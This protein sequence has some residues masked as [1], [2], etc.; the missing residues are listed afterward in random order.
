[1]AL[2]DKR[3]KSLDRECVNA[4]LH[5]M[6][7]A[8]GHVRCGKSKCVS[9]YV[10]NNSSA[11][12]L[13]LW[14]GPQCVRVLTY[15]GWNPPPGNRKMHGD[16]LYLYVVTLEDKK[17][18]ITASTHGFFLNQ[19]VEHSS[20]SRMR[21]IYHNWNIGHWTLPTWLCCVAVKLCVIFVQFVSDW[22]EHC[23]SNVV[24]WC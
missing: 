16:L 5:C 19:W 6:E 24:V 3:C 23:R 1:M 20:S 11:V 12:W 14:Q 15:S 18:H 9:V 10:L 4:C 21:V 13:S 17:Y 8:D 2:K 22:Q 7:V